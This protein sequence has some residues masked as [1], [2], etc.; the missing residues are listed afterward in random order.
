LIYLWLLTNAAAAAAN[1]ISIPALDPGTDMGA[2][3]TVCDPDKLL[4]VANEAFGGRNGYPPWD[5]PAKCGGIETG[6][7]FGAELAKFR[8]I[9]GTDSCSPELSKIIK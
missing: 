2:D 9:F 6:V 3:V 1:C 8:F 5:S 4:N 7:R